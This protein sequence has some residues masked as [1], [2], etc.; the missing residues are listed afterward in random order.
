MATRGT[1]QV[2]GTLDLLGRRTLE[3]I[4]IGMLAGGMIG[5]NYVKDLAPYKTGT[6]KRSIHMESEIKGQEV[7]VMI[8][9]DAPQT[10]RLEFG[11]VGLDKLG[12]RY[13][14]PPQ[15]HFRPGI[16]GNQEEIKDEI[17]AALQQMIRRTV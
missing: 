16:E 13:N 10:M 3:A 6:Y 15:P 8:G 17:R 7:R 9:S 14:Q 5:M 11:F 4:R 12:R 1:E 2:K